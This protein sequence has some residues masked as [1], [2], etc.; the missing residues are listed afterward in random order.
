MHMLEKLI[1]R[2][3]TRRVLKVLGAERIAVRYKVFHNNLVKAVVASEVET[4]VADRFLDGQ[5]QKCL[6]QESLAD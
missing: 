6:S 3:G 2:K 1:S 4:Y 5:W